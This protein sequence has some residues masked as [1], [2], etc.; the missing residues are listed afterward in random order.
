M[1]ITLIVFLAL[2]ALLVIWGVRIYNRLVA[3]RNLIANAFGQIDVQLKRRHDLIPNL[4]EVAR[5]YMEHEQATLTA[6]IQARNTAQG[7]VQAAR[8]QPASGAAITALAVAEQT[9][10]GQVGRLLAVSENYPDLKADQTMRELSEEITSSENRVSFARQAY[11]DAVL[12]FNNA[13]QAFPDLIVARLVGFTLSEPLQVTS[14][15]AER[16][17]PS[18]RFD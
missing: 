3:L 18:V 5:K 13:A 1:S 2:L 17:A 10:M 4:V 7:A 6:V 12:D 11:N 15:E 8:S 9:L 14:S 16:A